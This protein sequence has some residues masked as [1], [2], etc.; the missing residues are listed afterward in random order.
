MNKLKVCLIVDNPL[1]DIDGLILLSWYLAQNNIEVFLV[2]MYVQVTDVMAIKPNLVLL[3]YIRPN[4]V[5][6]AQKYKSNGINIAVLDAEGAPSKG[7]DKF[8]NRLVSNIESF[9]F[10]DLYFLWGVDQYKSFLKSKKIKKGALRITGCPRYDFCNSKFSKLLPNISDM[11]EYILINTNFPTVNPYFSNGFKNE[12]KVM[13]GV[14]E[15]SNIADQYIIDSKLAFFAIINLVKKISNKFHN[16]NFVLRPH[17]FEDLKAY[18]QLKKI[19]NVFV[20]Q[21]RTSIEW[22]KSAKCLIHLNCSTSVEAALLGKN[23]ISPTW[24]NTPLLN[25]FNANLISFQAKNEN[26]L[27]KMI[28]QVINGNE[29]DGSQKIKK[30]QDKIIKNFYANNYGKSA[31]RVSNEIIRL[32][33]KKK[34]SIYKSQK[35]LDINR[36]SILFFAKQLL[37]YKGYTFFKN[38]LK[39][40]KEI[41]SQEKKYFSS[42]FVRKR[43]NQIHHINNS[44][45]KNIKVEVVSKSDSWNNVRLSERSIRIN[46]D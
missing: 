29:L 26:I 37:G 30:I 12:K 2:P 33:K 23:S 16:I 6:L 14:G 15:D 3:N 39:S 35:F 9:D 17:P 31:K 20:R 44:N 4:N 7:S 24:L 21:E 34:K 36:I 1:R 42:N 18:D 41:Q 45:S 8:V 13:M 22:I 32:I 5:Y 40:K 10:L 25:V 27:I 19:K 28:G 46:I 43:I 38:I 11:G